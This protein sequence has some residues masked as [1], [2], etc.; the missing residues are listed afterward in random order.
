MSR[1]PRSQLM[2]AVGQSAATVWIPRDATVDMTGESQVTIAN[3][4]TIASNRNLNGGTGGLIRTT[5][6]QNDDTRTKFITLRVNDTG[7]FAFSI[8]FQ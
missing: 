4:V 8:L 6:Q 3:D 2:S 1:A 5:D 7:F